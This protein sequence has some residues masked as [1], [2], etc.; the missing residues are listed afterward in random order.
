MIDT[1]PTTESAPET[2]T[3]PTVFI[4]DDDDGVRATIEMIIGSAGLHTETYAS[5]P[6]FLDG[7]RPTEAGCVVVDVRMPG[8][9]GLELQ[10]VLAER[11]I[12]LP[13]IV[14]TGYGDV[15]N[16]VRAMKAGAADFIQ[17][18]LNN[19]VLLDS[20]RSAIRR[21]LASAHDNIRT[22]R[23]RSLLA[24]LTP[25][26]REVLDGILAAEPNKRIAANLCI[27][28]KTVEAHRAR[29]MSKLEARNV[30]ELLKA[31]MAA[32]AQAQNR[33]A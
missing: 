32:S 17:K 21:S 6:N 18:P 24:T 22:A 31:M 27:A 11:G 30:V 8:M 4:I 33:D 26:E 10:H 14:V 16:A 7:Y 29:L 2:S 5:A 23:T 19:E 20:V 25:R 9:S 3:E 28:E 13:V 15:D 1:V 12:D